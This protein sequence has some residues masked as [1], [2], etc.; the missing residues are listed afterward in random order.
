MCPPTNGAAEPLPCA[1]PSPHKPS[2]HPS[3]GCISAVGS[4]FVQLSAPMDNKVYAGRCGWT[5]VL[6]AE[7]GV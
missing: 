1:V 6:G 2:S 7:L 3:S 5:K 4:E